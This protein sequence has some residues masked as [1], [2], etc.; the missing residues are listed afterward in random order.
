M[1]DSA[2]SNSRCENTT[3]YD[4]ASYTDRCVHFN[5]DSLNTYEYIL[6]PISNWPDNEVVTYADKIDINASV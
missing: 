6:L 5:F 3:Y 2:N 1:N 4:D